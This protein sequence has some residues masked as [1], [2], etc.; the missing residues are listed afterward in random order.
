MSK[1]YRLEHSVDSLENP[2]SRFILKSIGR[3]GR[4]RKHSLEMQTVL[5]SPV[6]A[7]GRIGGVIFKLHLWFCGYH[8]TL[9]M[10]CVHSFE[11]TRYF[12]FS[13]LFIMGSKS[14]LPN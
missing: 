12:S 5:G 9:A 13:Q 10:N 2:K 6:A 8:F 4:S 1:S 11:L 7:V 3:D 14:H